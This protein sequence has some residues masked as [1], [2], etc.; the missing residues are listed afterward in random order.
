[1]GKNEAHIREL[2]RRTAYQ[3]ALCRACGVEVVLDHTG[4]RQTRYEITAAARCRRVKEHYRLTPVEFFE[5]RRESLIAR[6]LI[7]VTGPQSNAV[8]LERVEGVGDLAQT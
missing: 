4:D 8:G 1:M 2:R 5:D 6:P 3:K 7:Q